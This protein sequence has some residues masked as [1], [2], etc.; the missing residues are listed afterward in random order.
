ST[1]NMISRFSILLR[2][3]MHPTYWLPSIRDGY[4]PCCHLA[5]TWNE[6]CSPLGETLCDIKLG[7]NPVNTIKYLKYYFELVFDY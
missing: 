7:N 4:W 5:Y 3:S 6:I 1:V 2:S